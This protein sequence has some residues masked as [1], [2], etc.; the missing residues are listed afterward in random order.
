MNTV[1]VIAAAGECLLT[2]RGSRFIAR[3]AA[4]ADR[5]EVDA[6][7]AAL[8]AEHHRASHVCFAYRLGRESVEEFSSDAGEP[9][10]TAGKPIL[11]AL[12]SVGVRDALAT[13]VRYF[14]GTKLGVRGLIDAYDAAA[15]GA[16]AEARIARTV[17]HRRWRAVV[18]YAA[19]AVLESRVGER[20]GRWQPLD[21]GVAVTVELA[22][23]AGETALDE[24]LAGLRGSGALSSLKELE[25]AWLDIE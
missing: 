21:Y 1:P 9:S 11:D 24:W 16:L 25:P 14:G 7:V 15:R 2:V 5:E 4:V 10:G 18:D 17:L 20:G 13:V 3:A 6:A 19:A 12:R 8:R 23:P 22:F